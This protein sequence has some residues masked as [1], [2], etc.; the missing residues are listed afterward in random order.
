LDELLGKDVGHGISLSRL[1][2][3][4]VLLVVSGRLRGVD[5]QTGFGCFLCA[6]AL[7]D[8][9]FVPVLAAD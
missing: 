6:A 7:K 5:Q 9:A 2:R 3:K 8:H 1:S 4:C